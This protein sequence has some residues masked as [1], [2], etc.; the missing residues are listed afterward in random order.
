MFVTVGIVSKHMYIHVQKLISKF[1]QPIRQL[2][3]KNSPFINT[4]SLELKPKSRIKA[5]CKVIRI[6]FDAAK[7]WPYICVFS[8]FETY[9]DSNAAFSRVMWIHSLGISTSTCFRCK[10]EIYIICNTLEKL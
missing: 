1:C 4:N 9:V 6:R 8:S 5:T 3:L 7:N 2:V 10:Y